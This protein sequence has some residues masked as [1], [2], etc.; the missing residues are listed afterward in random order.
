[1]DFRRSGL[2]ALLA[3][4]FLVPIGMIYGTNFGAGKYIYQNVILVTIGNVVGA[5]MNWAFIAFIYGRSQ[6]LVEEV[7]L[8][9]GNAGEIPPS[10]AHG[11]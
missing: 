10:S 11:A 2:S 1:M 9:K 7:D 4:I 5:V 6:I 8:E 3:K